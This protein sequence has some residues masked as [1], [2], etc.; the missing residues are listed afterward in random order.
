MVGSMASKMITGVEWDSKSIVALGFE[1]VVFAIIAIVLAIAITNFGSF[2]NW[3][4][5]WRNYSDLILANSCWRTMDSETVGFVR[6]NTSDWFK[7][8]TISWNY[9]TNNYFRLASSKT[10]AGNYFIIVGS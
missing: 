1:L 10:K 8:I 4:S 5:S 9:F 6:F 3:I 2:K 7:A